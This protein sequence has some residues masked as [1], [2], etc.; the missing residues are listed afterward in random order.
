MSMFGRRKIFSKPYFSLDSFVEE[1][2]TFVS[3]FLNMKQRSM[4]SVEWERR[5]TQP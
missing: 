2:Y 1:N 3:C 5:Q 4:N